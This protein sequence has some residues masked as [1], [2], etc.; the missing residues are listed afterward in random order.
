MMKQISMAVVVLITLV[1]TL[2]FCAAVGDG[3]YWA[4]TGEQNF[5]D[6]VLLGI[7]GVMI[8]CCGGFGVFIV[9]EEL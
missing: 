2:A 9:D 5:Y 1:G 8:A 4:A 7:I 6:P 3:L